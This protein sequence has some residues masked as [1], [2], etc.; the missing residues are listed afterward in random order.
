M[1]NT[2]G[3]N[4]TGSKT[5]TRSTDRYW[6]TEVKSDDV[7]RE[8]VE[9][10]KSYRRDMLQTGLAHKIHRSWSA[11]NGYGP[12]AD[13]DSSSVQEA[14]ETG[15]MFN[16]TVNH[17]GA[18]VT[19]VVTLTTS[20]KPAVKAIATNT[21]SESLDQ[22]QFAEALNDY[23][24]RELSVS[25]REYDATLAM[26]LLGESHIA[27]DWDT[28]L[29]EPYITDENG[30]IVKTGDV[31]VSTLTPFDV[32]R[33][34]ELQ[35]VEAA[36]WV[37]YRR[38]MNKWELIAKYPSKKAEI[39]AATSGYAYDGVSADFEPIGSPGFFSLDFRKVNSSDD[40]V[41]DSIY[42]WEFR[43]KPTDA[44]EKG[45]LIR[46]ISPECV[47][48][49]TVE[50]AQI[51]QPVIDENGAIIDVEVRTEIQDH[52]YPYGNDLFVYSA[53]PERVVGGVEGHTSFFDLLSLQQLVDFNAS[54]IASAIRSGGLQNF[55]IPKGQSLIP[56]DIA[57]G[58]KVIYY[59]GGGP[60]PTAQSLLDIK[61]E[62]SKFIEAMIGSMR[63]R[64]S[65]N[66]VT[67][68][69][70]Q[71][72]MPA[73]AMALLRAQSVEFHSRLQA[74][75]ERLVQR[76]RTGIIKMLQLFADAERVGLIAGKSNNYAKKP[77]K[78]KDIVGFDRFII[79]PV[80][81]AMKTMAG[82]VGFAQ[83]LVENGLVKEPDQYLQLFSTGRL[84][85]MDKPAAAE[86]SRIEK[87]KELLGK[88]IGLPPFQLDPNG[89]PILDPAIGV[90]LL[91]EDG[92][93]HVKPLMTDNLSLALREYRSVLQVPGAR[94]NPKVLTAVMDVINYCMALWK[95]QPP[96]LAMISGGEAFP[97]PAT[98]MPPSGM[99]G[100]G[101]TGTPP[102]TPPSGS[103]PP[104]IDIPPELKKMM[105][106]QQGLT[107][108]APGGPQVRLPSPPKLKNADKA[109]EETA[110]TD[111]ILGNKQ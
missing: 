37:A 88:G 12:G 100:A 33:D 66:E 87:D 59:E 104:G 42:M 57:G 44:L 105:E 38:K 47:L 60:A 5:S 40:G 81:P 102:P 22:A 19:Q 97:Q 4:D 41:T 71:R 107:S 99:P 10:I 72:Q 31:R 23:Y 109:L 30:R 75:Y 85:P 28:S 58:L 91:A 8:V 86:R 20:L 18:L 101:M 90:P 83:M 82:K 54:I 95:A 53:A 27:V 46:F 13:R 16:I 11:Y 39:L 32:A 94:N 26:V 89:M 15:E 64:V 24:D 67:T 96:A 9:R 108:G 84:E 29:G 55:F 45:R 79:E 76:N 78:K 80:N 49:D 61:P 7:V 52:G 92:Q 111:P 69:D 35:D 6:A 93:E 68:G 51:E 34:T 48:F 36:T 1:L 74:S 56:D 77:F 17:Y 43:H 3:M 73:Q 110:Q 63:Q 106:Q 65:L 103:P 2:L 70:I 50:E 25:D 62:V 14:G 98:M 21:D